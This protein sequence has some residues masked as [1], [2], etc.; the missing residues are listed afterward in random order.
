MTERAVPS[1]SFLDFAQR[2][3]GVQLTDAQRVLCAVAFDKAEPRDL[4]GPD[5]ELARQLF[6]DV[7][8]VPAS[9]RGVVALVMG[10]RSG[11]SYVTGG[12]YSAW[13]AIVADLSGLAPGESAT[14]LAVAPD[15][16]L[17]RQTLRFARGAIERV[18]HLAR[19]VEGVTADSFSIRRPDGR[20]VAI[21]ALPATRG[22]SA[23]RG[24][25]L[26]S[27]VCDEFAFFRDDQSAVNDRDLYNALAPRVLTGGDVVLESTPWSESGVLYELFR[28]E[29]GRPQT[30]LV[31][32][33]PT[34]LMRPGESKRIDQEF[35]RDPVNAEREFNAAFMSTGTGSFIDSAALARCV[36]PD[37]R[38]P[39][40]PDPQFSAV[41][42]IDLAFSGDASAITI[43]RVEGNMLMVAHWEE[44]RPRKG[45]PLKPSEV[46]RRFAEV[47]LEHGCRRLYGD[48]HYAEAA[49][50][51]LSGTGVSLVTIDAGLDAKVKRYQRA[52]TLIE[53]QKV[54]L[55]DVPRLLGQLR[56]I[57][58]KA[59]PGGTWSI[60]H[61]RRGGAHGDLAASLVVALAEGSRLLPRGEGAPRRVRRPD[62]RP[63]YELTRE[64]LHGSTG[65]RLDLRV[66]NGAVLYVTEQGRRSPDGSRRAGPRPYTFGS[67]RN[68]FGR[69]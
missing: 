54:I 35:A 69:F 5:R 32:H 52:R 25:T 7:D 21:E 15:L 13:R 8:E 36:D 48:R 28:D 58:I 10:A 42:A 46:I 33:G 23:V 53:E 22:G 1:L 59:V 65:S 62:E 27:A 45:S 44:I 17:A 41:A 14:A 30:A 20:L 9:A 24:R 55:P 34:V 47:A 57:R 68:S 60:T 66:E 18:P 19:L 43:P 38:R 61:P 29:W 64:S 51:W 63:A 37:H 39:L 56:E 11:K 3:V 40:E 26:V 67:D 2:V 4:V 16:R 12:L 31:A 49:R 50:E 6:G